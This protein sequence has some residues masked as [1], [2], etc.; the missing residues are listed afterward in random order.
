MLLM[1]FAFASSV[2]WRNARD[3]TLLINVEKMKSFAVKVIGGLGQRVF[4]G[5]TRVE[6]S[7]II[8]LLIESETITQCLYKQRYFLLIRSR[9]DLLFIQFNDSLHF[10]TICIWLRGY[11][12]LSGE[13]QI[14]SAEK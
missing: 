5:D 14:T 11:L 9:H 7:G 8:S 12:N 3:R 4:F 10:S 6:N 1:L 13:L 2:N